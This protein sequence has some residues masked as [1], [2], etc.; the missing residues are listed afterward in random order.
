MTITLAM[1][2]QNLVKYHVM[3]LEILYGCSPCSCV[4]VPFVSVLILEPTFVKR[5]C[6]IF[7]NNICCKSESKLKELPTEWVYLGSSMIQD[8]VIWSSITVVSYS[9][10]SVQFF[11]RIQ[12]TYLISLFN[13]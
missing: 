4:W 10:Q 7:S 13:P 1:H 3:D 12:G 8:A 9:F 5:S 11:H 2:Y 6:S